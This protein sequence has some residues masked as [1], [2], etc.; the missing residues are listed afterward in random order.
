MITAYWILI[1]M[2]FPVLIVAVPW[3]LF[4]NECKLLAQSIDIIE[5]RK[6]GV[7]FIVQ[8][9][10]MVALTF[11]FVYS[12]A[13]REFGIM[14]STL[15]VVSLYR[16]RWSEWL[17]RWLASHQKAYALT[18]FATVLLALIPHLYT[19]A[20]TIDLILVAAICFTPVNSFSIKELFKMRKSSCK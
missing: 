18:A 6:N 15:L 19:L 7:K 8:L 5:H 3:L 20:V 13:F 11:H 2:F 14:F 17:L 1:Q 10:M 9:L 4:R 16:L 12:C